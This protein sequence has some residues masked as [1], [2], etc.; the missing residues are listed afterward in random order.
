MFP[1]QWLTRERCA[2]ERYGNEPAR[3]VRHYNR[4]KFAASPTKSLSIKPSS[5]AKA[6]TTIFKNS[7][8]KDKT[9]LARSVARARNAGS[10]QWEKIMK[11]RLS[12]LDLLDRFV[13]VIDEYESELGKKVVIA[14][15]EL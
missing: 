8:V 14:G 6:R 15:F 11:D 3:P 1:S 7:T 13:E 12:R 10:P 5:T 2:I 4:V 9:P